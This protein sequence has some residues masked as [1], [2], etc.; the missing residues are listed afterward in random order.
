VNQDLLNRINRLQWDAHLRSQPMPQLADRS[1][2]VKAD[3]L[4]SAGDYE[5]AL[6]I[7]NED[8]ATASDPY[9]LNLRGLVKLA[10]QDFE[11]AL[12]DFAETQ[13]LLRRRLSKAF[14]NQAATLLQM[15]RFEAAERSVIT[16]IE[17]DPNYPSPWVTWLSILGRTGAV[18]QI[19]GVARQMDV[20]WP[21]W[22][23]S[24]EFL[25]YLK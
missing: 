21:Q 5:S 14:Q 22:R 25:R 7:L 19:P 18:D 20:K 6:R 8:S 15:N 4:H 11:G 24:H 13:T 1:L 17:V 12:A 9:A 2:I 16:A 10:K 3:A 23:H